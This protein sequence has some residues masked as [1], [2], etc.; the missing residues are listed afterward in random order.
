MNSDKIESLEVKVAFV[1]EAL[2][3]LSDE[4]YRQQKELE[5]L[6]KQFK[7]LFA[8]VD[9]GGNNDSGDVS[10]EPETPPHY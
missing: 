4:Y 9:S 10:S 6:K 8:R 1:E 2:H 5:T 3:Q 7:V